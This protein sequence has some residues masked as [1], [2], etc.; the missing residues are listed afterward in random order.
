MNNI[1]SGTEVLHNAIKVADFS[2]NFKDY[3]VAAASLNGKE[4]AQ[5]AGF[6]PEQLATVLE[7]MP[8]GELEDIRVDEVVNLAQSTRKFLIGV[9]DRDYKTQIDGVVRPVPFRLISGGQIRK[10]A[11]IDGDREIFQ[12]LPDDVERVISDHDLVDLDKPGIEVFKT[13][14]KQWKLLVQTELLIVHHPTIV[15]RDA[16]KDAGFDL[17]QKWIVILRVQGQPKREVT[18]DDVVDLRTPGIEKL[19]VTPR[20]IKNGEAPSALRRHFELLDAD[21]AFLNKFGLRWETVIE[22]DVNNNKRRWLLIYDYAIPVGFTVERT[23]LA[24]EIPTPYPHA[25]ID[26]FYTHPPL[27]LKTGRAIES[28]QINLAISGH[29]FNGWS[30]HR[31]EDNKWIPA[32]DN[33][34]THLTLVEGAMLKE[35]GE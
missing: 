2:M 29:A 7:F 21:V 26:M 30:R 14:K 8:N 12:E 6:V 27:A 20:T 9:S 11:E 10:V 28:T 23:L 35:T 5:I 3:D 13:R 25:E 34:S 16:L 31:G 17:N 19:R 15:V 1:S 4:L 24:L 32:S 22:A 18:L 33:V